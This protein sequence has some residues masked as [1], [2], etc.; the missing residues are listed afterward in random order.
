MSGR[1]RRRAERRRRS[2]S[3]IFQ[4]CAPSS[5]GGGGRMEIEMELFGRMPVSACRRR[6]LM[7]SFG[8]Y[9]RSG[10]SPAVR[11]REDV[12][13]PLSLSLGYEYNTRSR[14]V[15]IAIF[16]RQRFALRIPVSCTRRSWRRI[17]VR[18]Q[19]RA[20]LARYLHCRVRF[21]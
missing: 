5:S 1:K 10:I 15:C 13:L 20:D 9:R 7:A 17:H 8:G 19:A 18:R 4:S 21:G 12:A 11:K 3:S 2:C 14:A 16:R 6:R